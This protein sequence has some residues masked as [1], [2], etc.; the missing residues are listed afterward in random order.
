[1]KIR[2]LIATALIIAGVGHALAQT[3]A[4]NYQGKLN[5]GGSPANG[6]YD[7]QF[8]L[9]DSQTNGTQIG[10]TQTV[11]NVV[12]NAGSFS[13][14]V[15]FGAEAF[16]GAAR[17]LEISAR[18]A[19]AGSFT[20]L[21]PRQPIAA[22]PYAVRSLSSSTSDLAINAQQLAGVSANQ[23][24]QGNDA[25]LTDARPPIAGSANY[26]QNTTSQQDGNFNISGNGTAA[27]TVAGNIL[28]AR[29]RYDL[30]GQR[31]L[32]A[33]TSNLNTFLGF[34]AG[35]SNTTGFRNSMFGNGAGRLATD[36]TY[37]SFFG[38]LAGERTTGTGNSFFGAESGLNNTSGFQNVFVGDEA[39]LSNTTGSHNVAMGD[40]AG[41]SNT[42]G[43]NNT[44]IGA[45]SDGYPALTNAT[46]IGANAFVGRSDAIVLGSI[47]GINGSNRDTNVGIG[48]TNP[49]YRLDVNGHA[50]FSG[51][52]LASTVVALDGFNL[53]SDR[54]LGYSG[55]NLQVGGGH[56]VIMG[57][58][59]GLGGYQLEAVAPGNKGAR[60]GTL[61]AGGTVLSVGGAGDVSVDA[62]GTPGGRFIIQ[63][64][65]NVGIGQNNPSAKL[66]VGGNIKF[67]G[68]GAGGNTQLCRNSA[69]EI[70]QCSSSRRYKTDLRPFTGSL[71]LID[72]L[73]P[74]AFKW[75]T[76][77]SLDLGLVAE[78]VAAV[79]PLLV[80]HNEKGEVEGVKYD[81]LSALFINAF[82]EQQN[83][84]EK[85]QNQIQSLLKANDGLHARLLRIERCL[86]KRSA[87]G[88]RRSN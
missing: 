76:D 69:G 60:F 53:N 7:F 42:T 11:T 22:T 13:A 74:I 67:T 82:K 28:N 10:T 33:Q 54:I 78:D 59:F 70:S 2:I 14:T 39:G 62:N 83:Q 1:M 57:Q 26:I 50:H 9:F 85:E 87:R 29:T 4:F 43:S 3:T 17:F 47:N 23:Y 79:E 31:V 51:N 35:A 18:P 8:A 73:T 40:I 55:N 6:N 27:G 34:G 44:F 88:R 66:E 36:A 86:Q 41:S 46:A 64:G 15:D 37:N 80:T 16:P 58:A 25:R 30:A 5:D 68:L 72:R 45:E 65:G 19:G 32:E 61:T 21:T 38:A 20:L 12:V 81:R 75:K 24:V 77:Q 56:S 71:N 84:I 49:L 63:E 52:T 48:T